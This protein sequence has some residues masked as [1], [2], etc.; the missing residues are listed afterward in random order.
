MHRDCQRESRRRRARE[1]MREDRQYGR[2]GHGKTCRGYTAAHV[3]STS[4]AHVFPF[5]TRIPE[6]RVYKEEDEQVTRTSSLLLCFFLVSA[7]EPESV[8]MDA[9][10]WWRGEGKL[11]EGETARSAEEGK[12]TGIGEVARGASALRL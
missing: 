5:T 1:I 9:F 4:H 3:W 10:D 2:R 7:M 8:D 11:G 6:R 12:E